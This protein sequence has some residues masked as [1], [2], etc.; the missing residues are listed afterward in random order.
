MP[1]IL[2]LPGAAG[3]QKV[4][5]TSAATSKRRMA[6][7]LDAVLETTKALSPAPAKKV[8]PTEAK[9]QAETETKQ[10]EVEATQVQAE[11]EAGPLVP[12]ETE[13]AAPEKRRQ[14]KL[15][16]KRSRLLPPKL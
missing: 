1:E 13:P 8:T 16:R 11:T 12:T 6:N 15:L 7:V 14:S 4:Q 5:K 3:L 9:S 2:S 10:A